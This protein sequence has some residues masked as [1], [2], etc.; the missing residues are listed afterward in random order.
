MH[1]MPHLDWD[2]VH[3][4]IIGFEQWGSDTTNHMADAVLAFLIRGANPGSI[5]PLAF[6]FCK[7]S[8]KAPQLIEYVKEVIWLLK[9]VGLIPIASVCD[10]GKPNQTAID[11]YMADTHDTPRHKKNLQ[12]NRYYIHRFEIV[13]IWDIPHVI[14]GFRD[15]LLVKWL[16]K[17]DVG[18]RGMLGGMPKT[19]VQVAAA[20]FPFDKLK[21][22]LNGT[23]K[24]DT[25]K[26]RRRPIKEASNQLKIITNAKRKM[27]KSRFWVVDDKAGPPR[28]ASKSEAPSFF[29]L[30]FNLDSFLLLREKLTS[31][32]IIELIQRF[33]NQDC[34]EASTTHGSR[35]TIYRNVDLSIPSIPKCIPYSSKHVSVLEW[36]SLLKGIAVKL[37]QCPSCF[38]SLSQGNE[39]VNSPSAYEK[40]ER[41]DIGLM[42][43]IFGPRELITGSMK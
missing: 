16:E 40:A 38:E 3:D 26:E 5:M 9:G 6:G 11:G 23:A 17:T 25:P 20:I 29:N 12:H 18:V 34:G 39:I 43:R 15:L 19:S 28:P 30:Q 33:H 42:P 10:Q 14:K 4:R 31:L 22:V 32:R 8:T 24:T 27:H 41:L 2:L 37:K 13:H 1:L 36:S 21:D 35:W 7:E